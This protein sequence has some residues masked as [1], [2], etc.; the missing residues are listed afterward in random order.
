MCLPFGGH[1]KDFYF[2]LET[3][4][5]INFLS[6][7]DLFEI[8]FLNKYQKIGKGNIIYGR[9]KFLNFLVNRR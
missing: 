2:F 7:F 3:R 5:E 6:N 9:L 4:N 1:F 8:I